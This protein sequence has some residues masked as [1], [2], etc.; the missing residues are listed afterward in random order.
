MVFA[1]IG[2]GQEADNPPQRIGL[3]TIDR[4]CLAPPSAAVPVPVPEF[5]VFKYVTVKV[6]I[7]LHKAW[8]IQGFLRGMIFRRR[9]PDVEMLLV[10]KCP[11]IV[12]CVDKVKKGKGCHS[13]YHSQDSFHVN[14]FWFVCNWFLY[15]FFGKRIPQ[16]PRLAKIVM[17][18]IMLSYKAIQTTSTIPPRTKLQNYFV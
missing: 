16:S 5:P 4:A 11:S 18:L 15:A 2:I 1:R 6:R 13:H 3:P 14:W 10:G 17:T 9:I 8:I 7:C 12:L